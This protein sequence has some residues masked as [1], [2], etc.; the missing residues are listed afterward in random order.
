MLGR[1]RPS[2]SSSPIEIG[3]YP[4]LERPSWWRSSR[5]GLSSPRPLRT[6]RIGSRSR[7]T[8]A[9]LLRLVRISSSIARSN[10]S[11]SIRSRRPPA[12][13]RKKTATCFTSSNSR[14][15]SRRAAPSKAT[16][17]AWRSCPFRRADA[18]TRTGDPFMRA[19]ARQG[20]HEPALTP[21]VTVARMCCLPGK[22]RRSV[23][24]RTHSRL[25]RM[26]CTRTDP[27]VHSALE[28]VG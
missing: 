16:P 2:A 14:S 23:R 21:V 5:A 27:R 26:M 8:G 22:G 15:P 9:P 6:S 13:G 28:R 10:R 18:R 1:C 19:A 24:C 11:S 25:R 7:L 3:A 20:S 4:R 12:P 17:R